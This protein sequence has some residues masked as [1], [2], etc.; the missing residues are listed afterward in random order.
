MGGVCSLD[1]AAALQPLKDH[2]CAHMH[3]ATE[4]YFM[5][6]TRYIWAKIV[7]NKTFRTLMYEKQQ[8]GTV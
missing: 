6:T 8:V 4:A 5:V 2:G 3:H 1:T 7:I